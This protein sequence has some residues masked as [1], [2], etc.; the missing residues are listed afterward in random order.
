MESRNIPVHTDTDYSERAYNVLK[1]GIVLAP[2]VAG[3]DKFF[4]YLT[5]WSQYL[6]PVFPEMLNVSANQFMYGVGIVEMIAGIG[7]LFKPKIF[8]YVVSAW[9]LGIIFNLLM[10][11]DFYDI[12]LR[13]F[14]LALGAFALGQLAVPHEARHH[15][16]DRTSGKN[17]QIWDQHHHAH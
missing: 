9:M 5:D 15:I 10:L 16:D 4:N 11:G 1:T 17:R 14:G 3:A 6:S 13:D 12:A 8:A 7:V 2:I